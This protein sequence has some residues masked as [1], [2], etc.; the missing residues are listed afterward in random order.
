VSE[1]PGHAD[2]VRAIANATREAVSTLFRD[3]PEHFYYCVLVTTGEALAPVLSAWSEEALDAVSNRDR[4]PLSTRQA[5]KWSYA[6][7]PYCGFGEE[8]YADVRLMFS[9]RLALSPDDLDWWKREWQ[10]RVDAMVAAMTALDR[11]GL[12]GRG[13]ERDRMP[14][15]V[16]VAPPDAGNTERAVRLNPPSA[17]REWLAEASES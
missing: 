17:L 4:D 9:R 16:E 10:F 5:L 8:H 11:E 15:N 6:D 3:H 14:I 13:A 12:F 7:S 2:L 1:R